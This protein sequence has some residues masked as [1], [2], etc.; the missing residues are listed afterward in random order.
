[1][2]YGYVAAATAPSSVAITQEYTND[3]FAI[4]QFAQALGNAA[5]SQQYLKRADNWR[6]ILNPS[7]GYVQPRN[8]DGSWSAN[9][10][11]T[12]GQGFQETDAAQATWMET[13]NLRGLFD[14]LGGNARV[15]KRLD[16]LFQR[17]NDGTNSQN[18]YMGNEPSLLTPWEYD[19]AGAPAHTQRVIRRIQTRLFTNTPG[20]LPGNDDGGTMSAWYVF[21]ALGLYPEIPGVGGFVIGSPLFPAARVEPDAGQSLQ[22]NAPAAAVGTPYVQELK[23]NGKV[24]TST[25]LPWNTV[26]NGAT[27]DFGLGND[28]TNWGS[29]PGDA[30]PSFPTNAQ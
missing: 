23:L 15:V 10:S 29:G 7:S 18:A 28:A 9:F 19:F 14:V 8:L 6:N 26:K 11:P 27:L 22:I 24:T 16:T 25:W 20:G 4:A 12:N 2:Q 1:M 30:P 17:L 3:D 21:S 13:F 5:V